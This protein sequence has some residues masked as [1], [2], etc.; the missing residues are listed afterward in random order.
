MSILSGSWVPVSSADGLHCGEVGSFADR[1]LKKNPA[2]VVDFGGNSVVLVLDTAMGA[3]HIVGVSNDE[4]TSWRRISQ[5]SHHPATRPSG[6]VR[7]HTP[8]GKFTCATLTHSFRKRV[9]SG[10]APVLGSELRVG[11]RVPIA[12]FIPPVH[13]ASVMASMSIGDNDYALTLDLSCFF[14]TYMANRCVN[15]NTVSIL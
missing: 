10:V 11:D 5:V 6:L 14:G 1:F 13:E 12:R 3:F 4:K 8:S 9:E 2:R 15:G 7:I